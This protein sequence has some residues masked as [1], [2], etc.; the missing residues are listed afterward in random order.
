MSIVYRYIVSFSR[1]V[2]HK[3]TVLPGNYDTS[4]IL[5]LTIMLSLSVK[6]FY[7][8]AGP[9]ELKW[10]LFPTTAL[11]EAFT[12]ISFLFDPGKGYVAVDRLV[13]IGPGCAGLNFFVIALCMCVF[14]FI[15]QYERN[16]V[17]WFIGFILL[18]YVV[19]LLVNASR[20]VAGIM[21][22]EMGGHMGFDVS[23]TVHAA[24][25]TLFYFFFLI[26]YFVSLRALVVRR[27]S[28]EV[29]C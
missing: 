27:G 24:Q 16:K 4:I 19:T 17:C 10:I 5:S 25:G 2:K 23:G 9:G 14:S 3:N 22:L 1:F 26:V 20:I 29:I 8:T 13:V 6:L 11:V 15:G 12:S 7:S 28:N 18:T 21:L